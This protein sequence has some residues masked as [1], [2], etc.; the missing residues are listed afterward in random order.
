MGG[1]TTHLQPRSVISNPICVK[2]GFPKTLSTTSCR[3]CQRSSRP[4]Y[5]CWYGFVFGNSGAHLMYRTLTSQMPQNRGTLF[6]PA[7][8]HFLRNARHDVSVK[9][10]TGRLSQSITRGLEEMQPM[11]P[12]SGGKLAASKPGR[13]RAHHRLRGMVIVGPWTVI[14]RNATTVISDT[15]SPGTKAQLFPVISVARWCSLKTTAVCLTYNRWMNGNKLCL[16]LP[17]YQRSTT[18]QL[19]VFPI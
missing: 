12:L 11:C 7:A 16:W 3:A 6:N 10:R 18:L 13:T 9:Y 1:G 2:V 15:S 17:Q 5:H 14:I 19:L 4:C 8:I